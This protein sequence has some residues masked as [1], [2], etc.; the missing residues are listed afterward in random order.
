MKLRLAAFVFAISFSTVALGQK[1]KAFEPQYF[2]VFYDLRTSGELAELERQNPKIIPKG[3]K[4]LFEIPSEKSSVRFSAG[5]EMQFVVR[6][7]EDFDKAAATLQLLRYETQ[8]GVRQLLLKNEDVLKNR[9]TL[10]L[11]V[12]KYGSSSLKVVPFQKLAP[13]EYCLSRSTISQGFCFGVD[14]AGNQ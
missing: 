8:N 13:G 2:S 11:N 5:D 4:T 12:E 9:A 14:S 1:E 3:I 7:T 6:V 10:K